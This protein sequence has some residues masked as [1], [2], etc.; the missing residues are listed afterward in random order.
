MHKVLNNSLESFSGAEAPLLKMNVN[1]ENSATTS[2]EL[3][4]GG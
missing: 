4:Q 3:C 1:K 2:R